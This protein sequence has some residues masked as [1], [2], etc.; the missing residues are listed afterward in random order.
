M[1]YGTGIITRT[2]SLRSPIG[3]ERKLWQ[4]HPRSS[5]HT[6]VACWCIVFDLF[7]SN[8]MLQRRV[9][10]RDLGFAIGQRMRDKATGIKHPMPIVLGFG[11]SKRGAVSFVEVG[12]ELEIKLSESERD[13]L[14][15][16]PPL[17]GFH[18]T[19]VVLAATSRAS[20]TS[21]GKSTSRLFDSMDATRT[22][23]HGDSPS[24]VLVSHLVCNVAEDCFSPLEKR[25]VRNPTN[26]VRNV[27]D[28]GRRLAA[29]TSS[30]NPAFT[31]F[32]ISFVNCR[33]QGSAKVH[34]IPSEVFDAL[35]LSYARMISEASD[36]VT[37]RLR[38]IPS[39]EAVQTK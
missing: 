15:S 23:A 37:E 32:G 31:A 8:E 11:E 9:A 33:N 38:T 12:E 28:T 10:S 16:L 27:L 3:P 7:A 6:A 26:G 22:A 1:D 18:V 21:V 14:D 34:P 29:P 39:A 20:M 24:A 4:Y 17:R 19:D 35:D 30:A 2:L 5:R 13:L 36:A 25:M